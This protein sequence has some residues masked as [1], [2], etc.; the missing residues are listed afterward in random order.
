MV[1]SETWLRCTVSDPEVALDDYNL[2]RIDRNTRGGGVAIYS[3][4]RTVLKA[5]SGY[6]SF[7]FLALKVSIAQN[8]SIVVVCI[9]RPPAAPSS[10]INE[11]GDLLAPFTDS[12]LIVLGNFNLN[13]LS[14]ASEYLKEVCDNI[15]LSQL[16]TDPTRPN[17]KDPFKSSLLD[18][19]LTNRKEKITNSGVLN[20]VLV[21]TVQ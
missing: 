11:I 20:L 16:I 18:L 19:I 9:Y 8:N 3:R 15:H 21:T 14:S 1:L 4:A 6:K 2:F 10:A 17:F 12:E 13:W 7:E 5:V